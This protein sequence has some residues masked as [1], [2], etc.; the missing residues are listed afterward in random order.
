MSTTAIRDEGVREAGLNVVILYDDSAIAAKANAMLET[1]AI[2]ADQASLWS[3]KPWRFDLL[4]APAGAEAALRDA[5]EAHLMVLAVHNQGALPARV[6]NWVEAW[7]GRR[8]VADAALAVV[9]GGGGE[10]VPTTAE[11]ELSDLARRHGLSLILGEDSRAEAESAELWADLR[12]REAAETGTMAQILEQATAD[13]H[14][15]RSSNEG[16]KRGAAAR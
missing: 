10:A 4:C 1:A 3:V 6:A 11:A 16:E 15:Q 5:E 9:D 14:Q 13:Y 7:A 8:Q 2:R 12:E